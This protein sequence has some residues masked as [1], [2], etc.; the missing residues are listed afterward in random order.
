MY[1]FISSSSL[2]LS[3]SF[4]PLALYVSLFALVSVVMLNQQTVW[5]NQGMTKTRK[6]KVCIKRRERGGKAGRQY[7]MRILC[8][9]FKVVF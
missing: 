9:L 5:P 6:T 1:P 3:L 8:K 4:G 2:S 7:G